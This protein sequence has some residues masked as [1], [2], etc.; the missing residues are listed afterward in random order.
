MRIVPP[1]LRWFYLLGATLIACG[2]PLSRK[3][4]SVGM[5]V[6]AAAWLLDSFLVQRVPARI[7]EYF[8]KPKQWLPSLLIVP[9]V[10]GL[11]HTQQLDW[12]LH[13]VSIVIPLLLYPFF[14][15]VMPRVSEKHR[16][17]ILLL[18]AATVVV[19]S[20]IGFFNANTDSAEGFRAYSPFID[21]IRFGL[22][23]TL[24][25]CILFWAINK[26][27]SSLKWLLVIPVIWL[28][29]Y[30]NLLGSIMGAITLVI[31]GIYLIW[32]LKG[33]AR[34][35]ARFVALMSVL[36]L[37]VFLFVRYTNFFSAEPPRAGLEEYTPWGGVYK[38]QLD[39][40][41]ERGEFV[42]SYLNLEE[43]EKAWNQRSDLDFHGSDKRG[44][45][46]EHTLIRYLN[47]LGLHKDGESVAALSQ[48]DVVRI[49]N[50]YAWFDEG[51]RNQL[52][53]RLD[54]VFFEIDKYRRENYSTGSSVAMRLVFR[55]VA[56]KL[57]KENFW[58]GVGTGDTQIA[59]NKA[60]AQRPDPLP[61]K[62]R[63]RAHDQY[64]T[65]WVS[66]GLIGF[67]FV[68]FVFYRTFRL[69]RE[70]KHALFIPFLIIMLISF[71]SD[72]TLER[73]VGLTLFAFF[74]N[75]LLLTSTSEESLDR[76]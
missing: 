15:G 67:L 17:N 1:A 5:M 38:H 40:G 13:L 45:S 4:L 36:A 71:L 46:L 2:L 72:D 19:V 16:T 57:I 37:S 48:D 21:H 58:F 60:H 75:L 76:A 68:L 8:G 30:L 34:I 6:F 10:L 23:V 31:I 61:E 12:G 26:L 28:V 51:R 73:Q 56:W 7:S 18:F 11:I 42:R 54:M 69:N 65:W 43:L 55:E 41:V 27:A 47:S 22:M 14:F 33:E 44:Q 25:I 64:M 20:V 53:E 70:R 74:F 62:Y 63:L 49:E 24:S 59:F 52:N 35:Y 32:Q 29:Y 66:W 9:Y 3:F 50:G 39:A